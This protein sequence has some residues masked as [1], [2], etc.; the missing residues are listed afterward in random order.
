MAQGT[1]TQRTT[2]E[3]DPEAL[4]RARIVLGTT[5]IRETIDRALH[6]VERYHALRRGADLIRAGGLDIATPEDLAKLRKPRR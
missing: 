2:V 5:T 1:S 3:L 4:A 6:E